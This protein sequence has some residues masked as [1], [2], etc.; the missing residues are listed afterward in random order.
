[1]GITFFAQEV[2][3]IPGTGIMENTVGV[4]IFMKTMYQ[5]TDQR[6]NEMKLTELDIAMGK[7]KV[8][9]IYTA[10]ISGITRVGFIEDLGRGYQNRFYYQDHDGKIVYTYVNAPHFSNL[11]EVRIVTEEDFTLDAYEIASLEALTWVL[12]QPNSEF[13]KPTPSLKTI[14]KLLQ[15]FHKLVVHAQ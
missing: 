9:P 15:H 13:P 14:Y 6:D 2:N 1:M 4:A 8:F 3:T 11:K 7:D 5:T 10:E 12:P